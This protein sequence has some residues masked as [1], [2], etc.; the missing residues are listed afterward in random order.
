MNR[1]P[2]GLLLTLQTDEEYYGKGYGILV[3]KTISKQVASLG[4][5]VCA[6]IFDL[7]VASKSLFGKLGFKPAPEKVNWLSTVKT[8]T[9]QD[10]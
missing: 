6:G 9:D 2:T 8:W 3:A 4:H 5:D 7:N 1:F 10:E